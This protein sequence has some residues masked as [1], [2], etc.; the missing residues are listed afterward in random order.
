M[1]GGLDLE[2][3]GEGAKPKGQGGQVSHA[4]KIKLYRG[5]L[6]PLLLQIPVRDI[7]QK[8]SSTSARK[9]LYKEYVKN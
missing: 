4:S 5:A 7:K 6:I 2:G 8:F 3:V 1:V 9:F